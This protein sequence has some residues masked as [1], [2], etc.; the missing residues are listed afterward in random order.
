MQN[1]AV[2]I[3][4]EYME[5]RNNNGFTRE[6]SDFSFPIE[7]DEIGNDEFCR[8]LVVSD[9]LAHLALVGSAVF[10]GTAFY[11]GL[12]QARILKVSGWDERYL[13]IQWE[14]RCAK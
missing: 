9:A 4:R 10:A 8:G 1:A 2:Y 6:F 12:Q 14:S 5:A 11:I 13:V 7:V 3:S